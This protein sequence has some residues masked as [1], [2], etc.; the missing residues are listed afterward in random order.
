MTAAETHGERLRGYIESNLAFVA[1]YPTHTLAL[2]QIVT[3]SA[4]RAPG[5]DQFVGAFEQV[6]EQLS[7][8][9]RDG[10]F[11]D[12]DARVMATAIRGAIDATVGRFTRDRGIDLK[13]AGSELA[14]TFDRATRP[15]V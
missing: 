5:V 11:G 3:G 2:V 12:F 7:A 13:A 15:R 1:E 10:E 14:E 4:Y 9:Q 6:A 8:G